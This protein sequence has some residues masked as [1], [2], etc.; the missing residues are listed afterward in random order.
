MGVGS[1]NQVRV[2]WDGGMAECELNVRS[3]HEI[4]VHMDDLLIYR[5]DPKFGIT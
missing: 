2:L 1:C 5:C 4:V 3:W